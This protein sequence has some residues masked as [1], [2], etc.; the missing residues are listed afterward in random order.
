[1]LGNARPGVQQLL[2]QD[3]LLTRMRVVCTACL[4]SSHP[5]AWAAPPKSP[6]RVTIIACRTA[7]PGCT[8]RS[9]A[10]YIRDQTFPE[11]EYHVDALLPALRSAADCAA[12]GMAPAFD[13]A[14][15]VCL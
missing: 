7:Q 1:M 13:N 6:H 10:G 3:T 9:S 2:G 12:R 14:L 15:T 11:S 5:R 4:L 8:G